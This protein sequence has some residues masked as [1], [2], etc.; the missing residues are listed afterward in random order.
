MGGGENDEVVSLGSIDWPASEA[1]GP[2]E[3]GGFD[4][5]SAICVM[6]FLAINVLHY[7]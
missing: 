1:A 4:I 7:I 2:P 5:D 3:E 6:N